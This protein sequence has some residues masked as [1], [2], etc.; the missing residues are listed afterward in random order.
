MRVGMVSRLLSL[1]TLTFLVSS[2]LLHAAGSANLEQEYQ[3]VRTIALRDP[4]VRAAYEDADRRLEEKILKIDPALEGYVKRRPS[5]G[6]EP[7]A[8]RRAAEPA[9]K[10]ASLPAANAKKA[11]RSHVVL[12]GETLTSIAGIFG[13]TVQSLKTLN[14][15]EDERKLRVGQTLAIP[16]RTR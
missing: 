6:I 15:I 4:K 9:A 14:H 2:P 13:V 8:P 11:E 1:S 5:G 3:Q 16:E 7:A 12:R 10:P